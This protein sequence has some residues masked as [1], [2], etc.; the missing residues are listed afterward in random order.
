MDAIK[1]S[2]TFF[3]ASNITK[4]GIAL[5]LKIKKRGEAVYT[6]ASP[7]H[8][9]NTDLPTNDL[10][11]KIYT[12]K[13]VPQPQVLLA[14]GLLNVKPRLFNPPSNSTCIP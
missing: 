13:L 4:S 6:T 1:S 12:A 9:L 2:T 8:K 10:M 11:T 3:M 14:L 5:K 7:L